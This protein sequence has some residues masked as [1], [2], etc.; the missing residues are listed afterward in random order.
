MTSTMLHAV[1]DGLLQQWQT[2][3]SVGQSF[4]DEDGPQ[5]KPVNR[6]EVGWAIPDT[7]I[8]WDG[9]DS[10]GTD[11]LFNVT[12]VATPGL[13]APPLQSTEGLPRAMH[14]QMQLRSFTIS[15]KAHHWARARA[16]FVSS[17]VPAVDETERADVATP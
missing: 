1:I 16:V 14:G 5:P 2:F 17:A 8:E 13:H 10:V 9:R 15:Q 3:V 11:R 6:V 12:V 7:G 4:E